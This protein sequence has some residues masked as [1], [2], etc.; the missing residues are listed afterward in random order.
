MAK[1]RYIGK[2]EK[3]LIDV[4]ALVHGIVID[5][6]DSLADRLMK[7]FPNEYEK[8]SDSTSPV[9]APTPSINDATKQAKPTKPAETDATTN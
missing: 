5:V 9:N 8:V 7:S 4:A 2:V 6:E 3:T 1:L